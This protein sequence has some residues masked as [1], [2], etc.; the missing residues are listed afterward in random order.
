[1]VEKKGNKILFIKLAFLVLTLGVVLIIVWFFSYRSETRITE[2]M[3]YI[4][5]SSL[6]CS[7]AGSEDSFFIPEEAQGY[8]HEIKILLKND[9]LDAISY[10]YEGTYSSDRLA[11]NA[12]AKFYTTYNKYMGDQNLEAQ[13]LSPNFST[14]KTEVNI[15]LYTERKKIN[16]AI[17]PIFFFN[18]ED[19]D[20]IEKY[21]GKD[22]EKY[23]EN[24]GFSCTFKE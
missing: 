10:N 2:D 13:S 19:I 22:F 12:M 6:Q 14:V 5:V 16:S 23:Y 15:S 20:K 24:K 17:L 11:E 21:D 8:K 4:S 18:R 7:L 1:M 3:D 9:N